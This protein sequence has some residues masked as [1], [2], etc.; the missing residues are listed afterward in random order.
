M[1]LDRAALGKELASVAFRPS[2]RAGHWLLD[3]TSAAAWQLKRAGVEHCCG[4]EECTFQD[5]RRFYSYRRDRITGRM[6]TLIWLEGT[7]R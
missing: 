7:K 1:C 5:E 3:L 2:G 6:A 4:A